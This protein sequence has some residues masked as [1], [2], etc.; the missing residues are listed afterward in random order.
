MGRLLIASN[1]LPVTIARKKDEYHFSPSIGGL[2]TGLKSFHGAQDSIWVGWPG[3]VQ[4]DKDRDFIK[5]RLLKEFNCY[6]VF[7]SSHDV[8]GY[9]G[10]FSNKTV[11]PLFHYF[12]SYTVY[13]EA[14]WQ[15][16]GRVNEI[17][18]AEILSIAKPDDTIW[19]HDYHFMLLPRLLRAALPEATIGFFLH[20]P[21]PSFELFRLLPWRREILAGLLGADL[22]GFHTYDYVRH[23][24]SSVLHLLGY[25]HKMGEIT[26]RDGVVKVDSFPMGI[27]YDRFS[28]AVYEVKVQKEAKALRQRLRGTKIILSIDRLDYTK[29]I[30]QRLEAF[31]LFLTKYPQWHEKVT[32]ILV[33]APSR[34]SLDQYRLLKK[35]VDE[36]V[37]NIN[38][39]Y[40]TVGWVPIQY[41]SRS[42]SFQPLVA[43]YDVAD[44]ALI[45]PLRDGMN[46]IAKEYIATKVEGK[47]VLIISEMAGAASELGEAV[48]I[49]PNNKEEVADALKEALEMPEEEQIVRN[50]VMQKRLKRWNVTQWADK[51]IEKLIEAKKRQEGFLVKRLSP[52][53]RVKLVKDYTRAGRRLI[54]LDYDGTLVPF[55]DKPE[56]ATPDK[57]VLGLLE[58]LAASEKNEVVL[59][60]GRGRDML[61][62]WFEALP[63]SLIAEHG[64]Y[65]KEKRSQ[66]VMTEPLTGEWKDEMRSIFEFYVDRTPGSFV[67]EKDFSLVFHYRKAEPELGSLRAGE[68]M[69]NIADLTVNSQLQVLQGNKVVEVKNRGINK[70]KAALRWLVKDE[71]DF[72]LAV[73]DD[74]TDE[75]IFAV[76]P[77]TA[78]SIKVGLVPSQAKLNLPSV[79]EVLSLLRELV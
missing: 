6:P 73:G 59:I 44:I 30:P 10:G 24:L 67:E 62:K 45:T 36:L 29:G 55:F 37:G 13:E 38:G 18:C 35:Q 43:M 61:E 77:E 17:F 65:I 16:Y 22:I 9:Y 49:N 52:G 34:V 79:K 23:F 25:D 50:R 3:E 56:N 46:L 72:V 75:Y 63:V 47:G 48:V 41:L 7:L 31:D 26:T 51:Y 19:I 14:Y 74:W 20:I 71:W 54:F 28:Q 1:R 4:D 66:W 15:A 27:D 58:K 33:T 64:L 78:Y 32:L 69:N 8:D 21:F 12:P 53:A 42:L 60:S 40:A 76:L 57:E 39:K 68:L 2:A 11:W 5:D 70:G